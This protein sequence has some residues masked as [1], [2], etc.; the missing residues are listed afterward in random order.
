M[1]TAAIIVAAG[2][3]TRAGTDLP[4]QFAM[5]G[6]R[7]MLAYSH[8]ALAAH[9]GID[10]ALIVIGEGQ[11]QALEAALGAVPFATGG[12]TRRE[13]V[14]RGLEALGSPDRVLIHDAARPFVP[15][16]VIDNP[17]GGPRQP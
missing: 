11:E 1:T 17:A 6:G 10:T 16:T 3:G 12:A 9:P 2:Q 14:R 5:L 8:A 4:K 13:S 15:A 7:P